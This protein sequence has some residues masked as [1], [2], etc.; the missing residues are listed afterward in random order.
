[1]IALPYE[2]R[3]LSRVAA[4]R[5]MLT[6]MR[7]SAELAASAGNSTDLARTLR[8]GGRM[9]HDGSH[10]MCVVEKLDD[11]TGSSLAQKYKTTAQS[12]TRNVSD[13]TISIFYMVVGTKVAPPTEPHTT[14][15]EI[16]ELIHRHR[17]RVGQ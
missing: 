5:Y 9:C 11:E 10:K 17:D 4:A 13:A 1:M 6:S 16:R 7:K 12:S 2:T 14:I 8:G 15:P 3:Y